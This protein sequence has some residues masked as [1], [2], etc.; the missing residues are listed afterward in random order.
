MSI[1]N[2]QPNNTVID[3][4]SGTGINL[5]DSSVLDSIGQGLEA[6]ATGSV[7][8][9]GDDVDPALVG[10]EFAYSHRKPVAKRISTELG[11]LS[12]D[13]LLSGASRPEL[14]KGIHKL[15]SIITRRQST[16][17]RNGDFNIYTG[18][19][20]IA[21]VTPTDI[22]HK[23][24]GSVGFIDTAANASRSNTGKLVYLVGPKPSSVSYDTKK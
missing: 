23:A 16:S 5:G 18:K 22:F 2:A 21:P 10:G 1:Y 19:Y 13:A 7:V 4:N 14:T 20:V 12:N 15:E 17:F 6:S 3:N 9:N 11:G 8:V 24:I